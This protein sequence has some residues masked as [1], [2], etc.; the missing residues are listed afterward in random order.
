MLGIDPGTAHGPVPELLFATFQLSFA[1]ITAALVSGA[2]ADRAKFAAWMVF[3]P[4]WT[5]A[6]YARGRALGVGAR[7]AGCSSLARWT[8]RAAW[9]SK[10]SPA[11]SALALAL[12]LGPRIGFKNDA[13]RPHNLPFVLLGVGLLWFGWFGFNAG[14]A[15]A[16]NGMAAAVFL[17][18]AGGRL[19][20]HDGLARGRADP[21]R[22]ADDLRCRL[23]CGRRPGRDHPFVRNCEHPWRCGCRAG[24][25]HRLLV[26]G[27]GEIPVRL[28]RFVGRGRR[29]LR[30][31]GRRCAADRIACHRS[32]DWRRR[33]ASSMAA[34]S[35]SSASRRWGRWL[36][37]RMR[38]RC[39]TCWPS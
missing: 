31:W 2:I 18:H 8:T 19:P 4:V 26:R 23:G 3:V 39:R 28:R 5:V 6:V 11:S 33:R 27:W 16:A 21:R 35:L 9:S 25:G 34:D 12:V 36:W 17:E 15:L 30:R 1:I 20:R 14:S 24:G 7:T 10:S 13:M 22:Q 29:A 38:S 32:D 37:A